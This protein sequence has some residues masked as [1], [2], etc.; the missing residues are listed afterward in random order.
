MAQHKDYED[1]ITQAQ[2]FAQPI[3]NYLR[4]CVHEACPEAK[5]EF[6]WSFP[7]FTYNGSILCNMAAF[8]QHVTFGFWLAGMM[9]DPHNMLILQENTGMGHFGK[10]KS[11]D[12]LPSKEIMLKYIKEAMRLTDE[13]VKLSASPGKRQATP[14]ETPQIIIDALKQNNVAFESFN[15]FSQSHRNEY[16]EWVTEAK[17]ESTQLKRLNQMF[18]WLEEGKPRN[19]KYMKKW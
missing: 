5:E 7:N 12:E 9:N 19:W 13:G 2:P 17:T 18:E 1:Y 6:K 14:L 11:I 3:L 10:I 15:S 4:S 16:I 8:K